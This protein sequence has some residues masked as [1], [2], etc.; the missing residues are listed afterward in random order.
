MKTVPKLLHAIIL[1]LGLIVFSTPLFNNSIP[2]EAYACVL[3]LWGLY[4]IATPL[5]VFNR[6]FYYNEC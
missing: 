4:M 2:A 6:K 3:V 1:I 5:S